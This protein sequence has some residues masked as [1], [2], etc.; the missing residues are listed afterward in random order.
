M[1]YLI[2]DHVIT[3]YLTEVSPVIY[4][5]FSRSHVGVW[6]IPMPIVNRQPIRPSK[7]ANFFGDLPAGADTTT[8]VFQRT[9]DPVLDFFAV[10]THAS[11][12]HSIDV[13]LETQSETVVEDSRS[14][15]DGSSVKSTKEEEHSVLPIFS[16]P[17]VDGCGALVNCDARITSTSPD[18]LL[19]EFAAR[20]SM[21]DNTT[22]G[23]P[24]EDPE[25]E[26]EQG[27][28]LLLI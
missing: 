27:F 8:S 10:R 24:V 19:M 2:L 11:A 23:V 16:L 25:T 6:Y 3:P 7:P 28:L 26:T 1:I 22:V 18:V 14:S 21:D 17:V 12:Y 4:G 5:Y 13:D 20:V 9:F 15:Q